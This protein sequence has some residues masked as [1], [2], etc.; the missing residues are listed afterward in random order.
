MQAVKNLD[1]LPVMLRVED[2]QNVL[3]VSRATAFNLV[4]TRGFPSIRCGRRIII[5][6]DKFLA[7]IDNQTKTTS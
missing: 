1:E 3:G 2:V 7:W 6:R 4:K 5:P